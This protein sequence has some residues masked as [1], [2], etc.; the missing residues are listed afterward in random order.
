[1]VTRVIT[2]DEHERQQR[3]QE[4]LAKL[5]TKLDIAKML[6]CERSLSVFMREAWSIIEPLT[7]FKPNYHIDAI[8][9]TIEALLSGELL[10]QYPSGALINISPRIGKSIQCSVMAPCFAWTRWAEMRFLNG[11]YHEDLSSDFSV[12]RRRIIESDWYQVRWGTKDGKP[13]VQLASDQNEKMRFENV[14]TGAMM[15][16]SMTGSLL[17][18]GGDFGVIDDP[19]K[20]PEPGKPAES[21]SNIVKANN[22]YDVTFSTRFNNASMKRRLVIMQRLAENDLTG[23]CLEKGG[24]YHL[25]LQAEASERRRIFLPSGQSFIVEKGELLDEERLPKKALQQAERD[26]GSRMYAAQH[27]QEP[28]PEG[29]DVV[30]REWFNE[31]YM[32]LPTV[33]DE[34]VI[35]VDG[36]FKDTKASAYVVIQVWV[37]RRAK[38]YLAEQIRERMNYPTFKRALKDV[39]DNRPTYS[40]CLI[41]D[42]ANGTAVIA[43]LEG[44]YPRIIAVEPEGGKEARLHA[45]TPDMEAGDV[46]LPDARIAPWIEAYVSELCAFPNALNSDQ[47]DATSQYLI[48]ARGRKLSTTGVSGAKVSTGRSTAAYQ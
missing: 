32:S 43:E 33:L 31:R 30:E 13:Y 48:W 40:A 21:S 16:F 15:G 22:F 46:V 37:T 14:R 8:S 36:S 7:P 41:E 27:L 38:K 44:S 34:I 17:G 4:H 20:P 29:G 18:F 9:E 2:P 25:K 19:H 11:T 10:V 45:S 24:Y 3:R 12:K 1:M 42:K 23:H 47:C 26:M 5:A 35:S 39:L 28:Y 6:L